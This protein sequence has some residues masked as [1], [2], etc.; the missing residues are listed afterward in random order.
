VDLE[1]NFLGIEK[2]RWVL[3]DGDNLPVATSR[4]AS[5]GLHFDRG[6]W[7]AGLEGFYKEVDGIS[8]DTQGF[9]NE[10]QFNGELGRYR[11][12]GVEAL[13]NYKTRS[14]SSWLSYAFNR[15]DYNFRGLQPPTFPN[16]LDIR[17][18]VTLG[19]NYSYEQFKMGLGLNYRTGRPYTEPLPPPDDIDTSVFPALINYS[20]PNSSRLPE[21]FRVDASMTYS[22]SV[23]ETVRASLG[24]S[25]LNL[26]GRRNVLN[27][28]FRL[29]D[30]DQIE[31]I[32]SISLGL[33]PNASFR[34]WF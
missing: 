34:I 16:N 15:N 10:D 4:Q 7:L 29:N 9:Q 20:E 19:L 24:A 18:T 14:W 12:H 1:Q 26:T 5:L 3:A 27:T 30:Q 17:H 25:V 23:S 8:T 6:Y 13:I 11:V 28:Y 2:R 21:Y 22:F 31:R 33:T 32:E